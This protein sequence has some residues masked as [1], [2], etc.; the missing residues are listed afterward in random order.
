MIV[1]GI[2][3]DPEHVQDQAMDAQRRPILGPSCTYGAQDAFP[4]V[5]TNDFFDA[6]PSTSRDVDL[7]R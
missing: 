1:A 7:R 3:G 6:V 2:V 4:A 5:R